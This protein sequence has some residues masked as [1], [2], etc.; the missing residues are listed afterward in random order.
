MPSSSSVE[1]RVEAEVG[2]GVELGVEVGVEVEVEVGFILLFWVGGVR[3]GGDGV[4]G[5]VVYKAISASN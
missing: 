3:W 5:E 2:V 1:V 4:V